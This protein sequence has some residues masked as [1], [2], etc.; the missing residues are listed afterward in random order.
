MRDFTQFIEKE[1]D[2]CL[3]ELVPLLNVCV[4]CTADDHQTSFSSPND[5]RWHLTVVHC[6]PDDVIWPEVQ[7]ANK[8]KRILEAPLS[9]EVYPTAALATG[10]LSDGELGGETD[11]LL[12]EKQQALKEKEALLKE[13]E[14]L[15]K[16]RELHELS[17]A[18][19]ATLN[20]SDVV[21]SSSQRAPM[22]RETHEFPFIV[23][24]KKYS[25]LVPG[26]INGKPRARSLA[27][28]GLEVAVLKDSSGSAWLKVTAKNNVLVNVSQCEL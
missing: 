13:K 18:A 19:P 1:K 9:P 23:T 15:L 26:L 3:M 10:A 21:A 11:V 2:W 25:K 5:L 12:L 27:G 28:L 14:A 22:H 16:E 6:V 4:V 17:L 8:K 20:A 24:I 7:K